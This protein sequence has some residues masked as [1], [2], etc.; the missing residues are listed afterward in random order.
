MPR[1]LPGHRPVVLCVLAA[2]CGAG[3]APARAAEP[4]GG[5]RSPRAGLPEGCAPYDWPLAQ[6]R[7]REAHQLH[8]GAPNFL[9]AVIDLGYRHHPA[10]EGHLWVNPDPQLQDSEGRRDR[11]GWDFAD[12]D[13]S[14]E[15]SGPD[16]DSDYYVNHQVFVAGEVAAVAPECR[17]MILRVGY[18]A[19]DSWHAA[20]DY[21]VAHGARVLIMPHGYIGRAA[22][23]P[24]P[25]FYQGTDFAWPADNPRLR[26]SL[27]HAWESGCLIFSGTADNRGRRVAFFPVAGEAVCAV[28]TSNRAGRASNMAADA[29]YVEFAAPGGER[30]TGDPRQTIWGLGGRSNHTSFEGGCMASGFA[31]GVA[32]LVWSR[33]PEWKNTDIRAL[34]RNTAR[35]LP[36]GVSPSDRRPDRRLGQGL[37]DARAALEFGPDQLP[38]DVRLVVDSLRLDQ[39]GPAPRVVPA[40]PSDATAVAAEPV[41]PGFQLRGRLRNLGIRDAQR[42]MVVV[43]NGDPTQPRSPEATL[44]QPGPSLQT[45]QL[46]HTVLAVQGL[47]ESHFAVECSGQPPERVWFEVFCLDLR[48]DRIHRSSWPLPRAVRE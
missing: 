25:L 45:R 10:L 47:H 48:S 21:A 7:V 20:V 12:N 8:R 30:G 26:E 17:L 24:T 2:L 3:S 40:P 6:L 22:G 36:A 37:L 1:L 27:D 9:V 15:Y 38:R 13:G 43:Y 29:D 32:A 41:Q 34:L 19:H 5:D 42:A 4:P 44:E 23:S 31:G 16:A 14:L 46:G 28:G 18:R 11:H 39:P 33:H 35:G